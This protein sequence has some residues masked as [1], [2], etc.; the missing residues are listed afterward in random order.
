MREP[1]EANGILER[2][3]AAFESVTTPSVGAGSQAVAQ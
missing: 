2:A 1:L 3:M